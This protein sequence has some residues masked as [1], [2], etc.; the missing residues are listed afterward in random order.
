MN[1]TSQR[2]TKR[3]NTNNLKETSIQLTF[4]IRYSTIHGQN[5]FLVGDHPL[6]GNDNEDNSIPLTYVDTNTWK[7]DIEFPNISLSFYYYY[8]VKNIDGSVVKDLKRFHIFDSTIL[9]TATH[10]NLIDTWQA[11]SFIEN[12]FYTLPFTRV[13]T[14]IHNNKKRKKNSYTHLFRIHA[15]L[16]PTHYTVC[17]LGNH[18]TLNQWG[19]TT[20]ILLEKYQEQYFEIGISLP[21]HSLIEYKYGLY[22]KK[23]KTFIEFEKGD[24]RTIQTTKHIKEETI[25]ILSDAFIRL[26][27]IQW[28]NSGLLIPV[29]SI[30]TKESFGVGEFS[31]IPFIANFCK[32][33]GLS[34][35]Q[36][37]PIHDT[38]ANFTPSDSYPYASI[39]AFAFHPMYLRL[40]EMLSTISTAK[41][42]SILKHIKIKQKEIND[43]PTIDY[44]TM[45]K[46]KIMIAKNIYELEY[47][48]LSKNEIYTEFI[49]TQAHW[50]KPYAAFCV[51]RDLYKTPQFTTW[52]MHKTYEAN[53]IDAFIEKNK[54]E[55]SF[56][57]FLQYHL[58]RQ[59]K[60][61]ITYLHKQ[62]IILKGDLPIGLNRYS[63]DVWQY[64]N[65]FKINCQAGAPP[66][67]FS[68]K[69]QNWEFPT[70]HWE[71]LKKDHYQWWEKRLTHTA[72][73][74]DALRIDHILGFFRIWS[75]PLAEGDGRLGY[76]DPIEPITL[77][78]LQQINITPSGRFI[79]PYI[80]EDILTEL[81][82][83][84]KDSVINTFLIKNTDAT[85]SFKNS[86]PHAKSIQRYFKDHIKH[87]F[88]TTDRDALLYLFTNRILLPLPHQKDQY[89]LSYHL[90]STSSFQAL[91]V[92]TQH[93]LRQLYND[94]FYHRQQHLWYQRAH[95]ILSFFLNHS[96]LLLCGEDLGF[97]T[98][99]ITKLMGVL[100]ILHNEVERMPK[101]SHNTFAPIQHL[102]YLS[103]LYSST[104]DTSTMAGWWLEPHTPKD[105]YYHHQLH[106]KGDVPST[107]TP[108]LGMN[109]L[110]HFLSS[111]AMLCIFS[112]QDILM[113][114]SKWQS[115][116]PAKDQINNPS[117]PQQY[118]NWRMEPPIED[119]IKDTSW[120]KA[121]RAVISQSNHTPL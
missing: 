73:Y 14:P 58:H 85:Y 40:E 81:F 34:V 42:K 43:L 72:Q 66:D 60:N 49:T 89:A 102:P 110:S 118:W 121:I 83:E 59:L 101:N 12:T 51:L 53:A 19:T 56:Y 47:A 5:I 105:T 4:Y 80:T 70:Y 9:S 63:V 27:Y 119:C 99:S 93:V 38:I 65:Y 33:I 115:K 107:I 31:D 52:E 69:G 28:K 6:L 86:F 87:S 25:T 18:A 13:F 2:K 94:F 26:P 21:E 74:F 95:D 77:Q 57:Y 46:E 7:V 114:N 113:T 92:N 78:E 55:V 48:R 15:P 35:I 90:T 62:G 97:V 84:R 32:A 104:H 24:N 10:Y 29:F 82:Q 100:S 71:E 120:I 106:Q 112:I 16:L 41:E 44:P 30:R 11:T 22:D 79:L 3:S 88:L 67:Y 76:F 45:I 75:I 1:I 23:T 111:S 37:L 64:P 8:I 61:A 103:V 50:L 108:Q 20:P 54:I 98:E 96:S 39:S 91:D 109:I 17:L 116:D 117:N 36:I 68:A